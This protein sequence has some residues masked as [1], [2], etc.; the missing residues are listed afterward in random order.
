MKAAT[1]AA[2]TASF[3]GFCDAFAIP[4]YDWQREAFGQ[5]FARRG[6]KFTHPL[7]GVSAPRGNGKSFAAAAGAVWRFRF[8]SPPQ[9]IMSV[10]LLVEGAKIILAHARQLFRAHPALAEGVVERAEGF[11]IPATGSRWIVRS[12]DHTSSRGE[13]PDLVTYDEIGWA[14]DDE[15]F[16]SLLSAQSSVLDP[17]MLVVSTVGRKRSGPLWNIKT[18]AE[19]AEPGVLWWH[20][21]E[22]GSPRVTAEYLARQRR[23][24]MPT[25]YAREH[26]NAW[27]DQADGFVTTADVDAAMGT[28]WMGQTVG[29][30]VRYEIA[31]DLGAVHDPTVIGV[32]HRADGLLYVD[33]LVTLQGSREAPVQMAA[34]ESTIRDV[35]AAF[36]PVDKIRVESWQGMATV[37]SLARLGLPVELFTPTAKAHAEEWPLLAQALASKTLVL[38]PHARLREELLNLVY[39][40]GPTGAGG[41]CY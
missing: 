30:G 40:V 14:S 21:S 1:L 36:A 15:L 9:T 33:R 25:Q 20:T 38:P 34:V 16:S 26:Q 39:D 22:N 37:Q 7:A 6:G 4:L 35:A 11:E 3:P 31:V 18:L 10:G 17:L 12:R 23:L 41:G 24:L 19:S 32:G 2:V 28:G 5:A 8:G 29:G 13:H 27:V